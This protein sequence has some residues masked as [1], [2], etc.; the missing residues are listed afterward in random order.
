[1]LNKELEIILSK[2]EALES[3]EIEME[4]DDPKNRNYF[5]SPIFKR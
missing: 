5:Y 3:L 4:V 1:M 2:I